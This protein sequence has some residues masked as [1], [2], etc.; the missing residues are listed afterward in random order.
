MHAIQ[1]IF[2]KRQ[3]QSTFAGELLLCLCKICFYSICVLEIFFIGN[4]WQV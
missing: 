4:T 2:E 1:L 3:M